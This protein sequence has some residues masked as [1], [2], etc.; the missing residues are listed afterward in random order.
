MDIAFEHYLKE[1]MKPS[2]LKCRYQ[3]YQCIISCMKET[4]QSLTQSGT[5]LLI[6]VLLQYIN[7]TVEQEL[8]ASTTWFL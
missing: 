6:N 2:Q 4:D 7:K 8:F 1:N 5:I 3:L